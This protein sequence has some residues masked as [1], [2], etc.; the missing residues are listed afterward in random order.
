MTINVSVLLTQAPVAP[1]MGQSYAS[2]YGMSVK[3]PMFG[4]IGGSPVG[5][6]YPPN[7][8]DTVDDFTDSAYLEFNWAV[9]GEASGG[10]GGGGSAQFWG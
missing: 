1:P 6:V 3:G 2:L 8:G 7:K 10:A 4:V 5:G 9:P